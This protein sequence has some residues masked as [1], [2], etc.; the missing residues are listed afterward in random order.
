MLPAARQPNRLLN[1]VDNF[2]LANPTR[3]MFNSVIT[4]ITR[5]TR[6][7]VV[8]VVMVVMVVI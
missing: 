2:L 3:V 5:I 1:D 7:T 6:I 8:M 4:G